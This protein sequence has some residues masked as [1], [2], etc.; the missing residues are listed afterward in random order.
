MRIPTI[1]HAIGPIESSSRARRDREADEQ[2]DDGRQQVGEELPD[3]VDGIRA[4]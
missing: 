2:E 1:P 4:S 3:R